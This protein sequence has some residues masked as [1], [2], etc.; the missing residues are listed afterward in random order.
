MCPA[1]SKIK[2]VYD[3]ASDMFLPEE[4]DQTVANHYCLVLDVI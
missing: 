3:R 2:H 1:G 4:N